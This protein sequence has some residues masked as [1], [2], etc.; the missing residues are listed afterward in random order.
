MAV[1]EPAQRHQNRRRNWRDYSVLMQP[2]DEA[3]RDCD[4][5]DSFS[6]ANSSWEESASDTSRS[7]TESSSTSCLPGFCKVES[8][9]GLVRERAN[10]REQ[11]LRRPFPFPPIERTSGEERHYR[12]GR[13]ER[14]RNTDEM[15][16]KLCGSFFVEAKK[17]KYL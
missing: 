4:R 13:Q 5:E 8:A 9:G 3:G 15:Q 11:V 12:R 10:A 1:S 6:A 14:Q 17:N 16:A 7:S 2:M